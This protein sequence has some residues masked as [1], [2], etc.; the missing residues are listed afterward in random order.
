MLNMIRAEV[1]VRDF[2][3]WMGTRR[4][5][6]PDHAMHCLLAECFGEAAPKPFRAIFPRGS[7]GGVL[8]GYGQ[9]DAGELR[10]AANTY[11][12]PLQ[13]KIIPACSLDGKPMVSEWQ[14]GKRIGFEVR[15]RPI[16]RRSTKADSRPGKEWDAFQ[17]EAD[18]HPKGEMPRTREEVYRDWLSGQFAAK[19]GAGLEWAALQ[20][21]QLTRSFRLRDT[22]YSEGPDAVMRGTLKVADPDAFAELLARG[23][24]RHRAYGYGMLLLRPAGRDEPA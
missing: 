17:A 2:Q 20:S 22:R 7:F 12:D 19:G 18:N 23:V 8:Y 16:I 13:A 24:G 14:R 11:A 1:N 21:F 15:I 9:A 10:E 4:L 5:Q 6:D 3:C